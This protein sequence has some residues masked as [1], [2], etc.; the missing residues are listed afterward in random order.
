MDSF[1]YIIMGMNGVS[2][3]D[4]DQQ[5]NTCIRDCALF[6][7]ANAIELAFKGGPG[8]VMGVSTTA[9]AFP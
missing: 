7:I 4:C 8:T 6:S 2:T 3:M 9:G 5:N 1:F